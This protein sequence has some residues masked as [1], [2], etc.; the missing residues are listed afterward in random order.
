MK[1]N[2][3]IRGIGW[4]NAE[5]SNK[6]YHTIKGESWVF[7]QIVEWSP[8]RDPARWLLGPCPR[9]GSST[10]TYGGSY[11][12]HNDYC[13]NSASIFVCSPE[14]TPDWWNTDIDVKMDGDKWCA[15]DGSFVNLQESTAGFGDTPR[16]AVADY[17]ANAPPTRQGGRDAKP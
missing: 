6:V 11:S 7:G 15:T 3:R 2:E 12:C 4:H 10:S 14:P 17:L 13:Q 8:S 9:C 16:D 1:K 5:G